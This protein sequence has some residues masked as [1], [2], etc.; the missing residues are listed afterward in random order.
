VIYPVVVPRPALVSFLLY[1]IALTATLAKPSAD[2]PLRA[3]L[4]AE[5]RAVPA[6]SGPQAAAKLPALDISC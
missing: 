3:A 2:R 5:R 6:A 4:L 1:L